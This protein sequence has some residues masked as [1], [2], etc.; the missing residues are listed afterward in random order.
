MPKLLQLK[1]LFRSFINFAALVIGLGSGVAELAGFSTGVARA[2]LAGIGVA[3]GLFL[4]VRFWLL[5]HLTKNEELK[6]EL[7][8]ANRQLTDQ[9]AGHQLYVDAIEHIL[10]RETPLY[11]EKLEV[12]ITIGVDDTTDT[13]VER[14]QTTPHRRVMHRGIRPIVPVDGQRVVRM[15]DIGFTATIP[16]GPGR[17]TR[18]ALVERT[19]YLRV[20]L[21]FES[22]LT[23]PVRW[24]VEYR[25]RG[26][27]APLR[28]RGW[29]HLAWNDRLPTGNGGASALT[30]LRFRFVFPNSARPPRLVELHDLGRRSAARRIEGTDQWLIEWRDAQPAGRRYEWDL[31]QDL[32]HPN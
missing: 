8:E 25:P 18:F 17:I 9:R 10:D 28:Q 2:A 11:Q 6:R 19:Q 13:I 23:A 3:C 1:A 32:G 30:D 31:S 4:G 27:W 24:K 15:D 16:D 14:R 7:A 29:D 22:G 12:T 21:V 5:C 20:W 26:L